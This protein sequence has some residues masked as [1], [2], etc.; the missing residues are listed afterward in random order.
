MKGAFIWPKLFP[1]LLKIA[2]NCS[3]MGMI[4]TMSKCFETS[5]TKLKLVFWDV[6][7]YGHVLDHFCSHCDGGLTLLSQCDAVAFAVTFPAIWE[8]E[9]SKIQEPNRYPSRLHRDQKFKPKI[10]KWNFQSLQSYMVPFLCTDRKW[11]WD[12]QARISM[13]QKEVFKKFFKSI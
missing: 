10:L 5:W 13:F 6:T 8:P 2:I 11:T 12:I 9:E 4:Q 3:R 1:K 7:R